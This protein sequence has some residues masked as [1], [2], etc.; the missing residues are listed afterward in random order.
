MRVVAAL[1]AAAV[2]QP[3]LLEQVTLEVIRHLKV[4]VAAL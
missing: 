3:A 4:I 1:A 2:T